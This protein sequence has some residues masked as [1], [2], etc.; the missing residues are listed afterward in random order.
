MKKL[1]YISIL[2]LV[3]CTTKKPA[4]FESVSFKEYNWYKIDNPQK[5]SGIQYSR[6]KISHFNS[7][8]Y[9]E[10]ITDSV[11]KFEADTIRK[12]YYNLV[13]TVEYHI[14]D[15]KGER[16]EKIIEYNQN[17]SHLE[18]T[19]KND[20]LSFKRIT[21]SRPKLSDEIPVPTD[22]VEQFNYFDYRIYKSESRQFK[23][24]CFGY[25]GMC[26]D[27][28]YCIYF[29]KEFGEIASYS[30]DWDNLSIIDSIGNKEKYEYIKNLTA[31]L[32]QDTLFFPYPDSIKNYR[33]EILKNYR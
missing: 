20:S 13:D 21:Y 29:S 28:D 23:I 31:K 6:Q 30:I 32:K 9:T 2:I 4:G 1:L 22:T 24:F 14:L 11:Y 27:C 12:L 33:N 3:T 7:T 25:I 5:E 17:K 15:S 18:L 19:E 16:N 8:W 26:D 10:S